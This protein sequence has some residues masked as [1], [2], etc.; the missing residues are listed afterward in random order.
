LLLEGP[1]DIL[2]SLLPPMAV[3]LC[4][5]MH[6]PDWQRTNGNWCAAVSGV[7]KVYVPCA[8]RPRIIDL[9]NKPDDARERHRFLYYG[10]KKWNL[11]KQKST[12]TRADFMAALRGAEVGLVRVQ[13]YGQKG[14]L[15][16]DFE[17]DWLPALLRTYPSTKVRVDF[18]CYVYGRQGFATLAHTDLPNWKT[19]EL[20]KGVYAGT[21]K[22]GWSGGKLNLVDCP[23]ATAGKAYCVVKHIMLAKLESGFGESLQ[24]QKHALR[25]VPTIDSIRRIINHEDTAN[26]LD[27]GARVEVQLW[28]AK[29]MT[30]VRHRC[31]VACAIPIPQRRLAALISPNLPASAIPTYTARAVLIPHPQ[32]RY[33]PRH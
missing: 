20:L 17:N 9:L 15:R 4:R 21:T 22:F 18:G 25:A 10:D 31:R 13:T 33:L 19:N 30:V 23:N 8:K 6:A 28:G 3:E 27:K 32:D 1:V 5:Y 2:E 29:D 24:L 14:Q 7:V 26:Y 12:C 11:L 16:E